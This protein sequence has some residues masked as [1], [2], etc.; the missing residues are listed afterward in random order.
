MDLHTDRQGV[1]QVSE[2]CSPP[3][4]FNAAQLLHA[5]ELTLPRA[6]TFARVPRPLRAQRHYCR[7]NLERLSHNL[8]CRKEKRSRSLLAGLTDSHDLKNPQQSCNRY[9]NM[10]S[11]AARNGIA[12]PVLE[13]ARYNV[14]PSRA[15]RVWCC[16]SGTWLSCRR[17]ARDVRKRALQ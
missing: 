12:V 16:G 8:S 6:T 15:T 10:V 9:I 17:R 2:A 13:G 11:V 5:H 7:M 14:I 4:V 3:Y 1:R